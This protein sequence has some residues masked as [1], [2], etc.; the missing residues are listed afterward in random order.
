MFLPKEMDY[1]Q[2]V[3]TAAKADS[4]A[5]Q[6]E[7]SKNTSQLEE[8]GGRITDSDRDDLYCA[9]VSDSLCLKGLSGQ[10]L[11][12]LD[13]QLGTRGVTLEQTTWFNM[14]HDVPSNAQNITPQAFDMIAFGVAKDKTNRVG[15]VM[16]KSISRHAKAGWDV[17]ASL[18]EL[19]AWEVANGFQLLNNIK[20]G[21]SAWG[22]STILFPGE[23]QA[24]VGRLRSCFFTKQL[25]KCQKRKQLHLMRHTV[26]V[27]L[28]EEGTNPGDIDTQMDWNLSKTQRAYLQDPKVSL[29]E[30]AILAGFTKGSAQWRQHHHLG[31]ADVCVPAAWVD[32]LIPGLSFLL[33][34]SKHYYSRAQETL[35]CINLLVQACWQALPI[36]MLLY[37]GSYMKKQLPGVLGVMT[38]SEYAHFAGRVRQAELDSMHALGFN[39]PDLELWAVKRSECTDMPVSL[40]ET[41]FTAFAAPNMATLEPPAKRQKVQNSNMQSQSR[42]ALLQ[43]QQ[44]CEDLEYKALGVQ[45]K[46]AALELTIEQAR[47]AELEAQHKSQQRRASWYGGR[48]QTAADLAAGTSLCSLQPTPVHDQYGMTDCT[49]ANTIKGAVAGQAAKQLIDIKLFKHKT[50][51]EVWKEW[52]YDTAEQVSVKSGLRQDNTGRLSL[53]GRGYA[54]NVSR[55]LQQKRDLPEAIDCRIYEQG[56]PVALQVVESLAEQFELTNS[57]PNGNFN[58]FYLRKQWKH[59][60]EAKASKLVT[61]QN[62]RA[63][64]RAFDKAYQEAVCSGQMTLLPTA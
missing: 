4:V 55:Q 32:A 7:I 48:L 15:K 20:H 9:C 35:K 49:P 37:Q 10:V 6:L 24:R 3:V 14:Y 56:L 63:T 52:H 23:H 12:G 53:Y 42:S 26:T 18:A 31:R 61:K 34:N 17:F 1:L 11:I 36:K 60:D 40:R 27:M 8:H 64:V 19:L 62:L 33:A 25:P 44:E 57:A 30:Q 39:V 51:R 59:G 50:V 46:A 29:T 2:S 47:L 21:N 28:A 58:A 41:D 43:K 22:D 13:L 16:Y 5:I 54:R 38:S 45:T